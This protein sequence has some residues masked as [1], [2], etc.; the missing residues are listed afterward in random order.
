MGTRSAGRAKKGLGHKELVG[1]VPLAAS[2]DHAEPPPAPPA[3]YAHLSVYDPA[4]RVVRGGRGADGA[5][6]DL[7]KPPKAL[8]ERDKLYACEDADRETIMRL[9][10]LAGMTVGQLEYRRLH[11]TQKKT[12]RPGCLT[13]APDRRRCLNCPAWR[14][15]AEETPF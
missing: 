9:A 2:P 1:A 10:A 11:W 15:R 6:V 4:A 12:L 14:L 5:P 7:T 3:K 8:A 13:L